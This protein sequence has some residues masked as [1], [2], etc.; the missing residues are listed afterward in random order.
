MGQ[1]SLYLVSIIPS[2]LL[3]LFSPPSQADHVLACLT[4]PSA[5]TQ[6]SCPDCLAAYAEL[7]AARHVLSRLPVPSA[8]SQPDLQPDCL[9]RLHR[10]R[11]AYQSPAAR[12]RTVPLLSRLARTA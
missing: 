11:A 7:N 4:V 1:L 10:P 8:T 2:I 9:A 5:A 12:R 3:P 6:P